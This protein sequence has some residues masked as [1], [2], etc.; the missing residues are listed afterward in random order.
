[1]T[2]LQRLDVGLNQL[3]RLPESLGQLTQLQKLYVSHNQLTRLPESLGRLTQLQ[4]LDVGGNQLTSLPEALGQLTQL[5]RLDVGGNRL[6]SLPEALGQ[7]TGLQELYL[8]GNQA[9]GLP[10]EILGPTLYET[11]SREKTSAPPQEILAYYFRIREGRRPLNEAKLIL[12]GFGEVG[13]SSLVD[14]LV[15]DTFDP[16]KPQTLGIQISQWPLD[17]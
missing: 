2:Q 5:Q 3:T 13:K 9:L 4:K 8:S 10:P 17:P 6:T 11:L 14:R 15:L 1:L 7:L 16:Q 12:V